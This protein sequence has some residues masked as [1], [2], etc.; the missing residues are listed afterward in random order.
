MK[1]AVRT[2]T[3]AVL[4]VGAGLLTGPASAAGAEPPSRA[5]AEAPRARAEPV[6]LRWRA[7]QQQD[8]YGYLVYRSTR[9]DGPYR[10][11][12]AE[13]VH[14]RGSGRY[15]WRDRDVEPGV[16]YYYYLD[17]VSTSGRKS[18]FSGVQEKTAIQSAAPE[19]APERST[20]TES[21]ASAAASA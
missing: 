12:S 5:A 15:V 19:Q 13:I 9:R 6:V 1:H 20:D 10:R 18:R 7:R 16:T 2:A 11:T 4:V 3:L 21:G 8:V 17:A 14:R